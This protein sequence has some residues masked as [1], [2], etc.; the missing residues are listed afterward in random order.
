MAIQRTYAEFWPFYLG[1]HS[2]PGTRSS[3]VLAISFLQAQS[4]LRSILGLYSVCNCQ[5]RL[6]LQRDVRL[7]FAPGYLGYQ[8]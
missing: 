6:D 1:E 8:A 5:L 7:Y 2:K 3:G 4:L